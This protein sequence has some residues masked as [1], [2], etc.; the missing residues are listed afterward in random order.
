MEISLKFLSES[1]VGN[2]LGIIGG[3]LGLWTFIDNY[4]LR[5][6]P[7]IFIGSKAVFLMVKKSSSTDRFSIESII[8][9]IEVANQRNKYGLI[10]DYAVR[11]YKS[12]SINPAEAIYFA[13]EKWESL[14][15]DIKSMNNIKKELF[16][17]ISVL[18]KSHRSLNIAFSELLYHS[19]VS[20]NKDD[21]FYLELY[22]QKTP[23]NK[24]NY[25]G[26]FYLY[27]EAESTN[28]TNKLLFTYTLFEWQRSRDKIKSILKPAKTSLYMGSTHKFL[29]LFFKRLYWQ[30]LSRQFYRLRDALL[31][32][33]YLI[34]ILLNWLFD[35]TIRV[36][37]LRKKGKELDKLK[38]D[39][40][41][42][43]KKPIT[44]KSFNKIDNTLKMEIQ[45]IN[46]NAEKSAIIKYERENDQ[47]LMTRNDMV[48]KIYRSGDSNIIAHQQDIFLNSRLKFEMKLKVN[49]LGFHYWY[50]SNY[51]ITTSKSFAL[52][53][54]DAFL[55]HSCY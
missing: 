27:N 36:H 31:L 3:S 15:S 34:I 55:L 54:L 44:Q 22:Y 18:P 32:I 38:I 7:K 4:I 12:N 2:L 53:I 5:F 40:G 47:I 37:I 43:E 20:I 52:K 24:W 11:V 9:S 26:T 41:E 10:H 50:Q 42:P 6:N 28:E 51:G 29:K 17:P 13:S 33:P 8:L 39:F 46:S 25:V 30:I 45:K 16:S 21:I 48:I 1:W 49:N 35:H 19:A 14:I 23:K